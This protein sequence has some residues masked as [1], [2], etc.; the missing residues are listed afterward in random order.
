M[1][2]LETQLAVLV[3]ERMDELGLSQGAV[4]QR[5][6]FDQSAVSRILTSSLSSLSMEGVLRLAIGLNVSPEGIFKA[7][8]QEYLLDLLVKSAAPILLEVLREQLK[9]HGEAW[10]I[11]ERSLMKWANQELPRKTKRVPRRRTAIAAPDTVPPAAE[12]QS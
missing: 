8:R 11:V 9:E 6:G 2:E 10:S 3:R 12:V 5:G 4:A 1:T 7:I